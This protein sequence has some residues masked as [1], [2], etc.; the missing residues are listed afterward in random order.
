MLSGKYSRGDCDRIP[1]NRLRIILGLVNKRSY[2]LD[3]RLK[4]TSDCN[5]SALTYGFNKDSLK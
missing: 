1:F 3:H 4:K 5:D 2:I